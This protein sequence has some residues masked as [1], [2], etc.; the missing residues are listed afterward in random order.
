MFVCFTFVLTPETLFSF[1]HDMTDM[2]CSM[3]K[4][5]NNSLDSVTQ[6]VTS[7]SSVVPVAPS[8]PTSAPA[9]RACITGEKS[10]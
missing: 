2:N 3:T 6:S 5:V 8:S 1:E 7:P 10:L 9:D 4:T